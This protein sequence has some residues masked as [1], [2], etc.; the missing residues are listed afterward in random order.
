MADI[1]RPVAPL[2][3]GKEVP[4]FKRERLTSSRGAVDVR[5]RT[6]GKLAWAWAWAWAGAGRTQVWTSA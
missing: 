6:Y 5:D 2:Y 1:V 4:T 3:R